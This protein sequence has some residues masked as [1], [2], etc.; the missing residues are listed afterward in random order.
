MKLQEILERISVS[1]PSDWELIFRPTFRHRFHEILNAD[2]DVAALDQDEH[3]VMFTL[4]S[5]IEISM[6]YGL[7]E[8]GAVPL[9]PDN[10]FANE[11]A[12]TVYLDIFYQGRMVHREVV[13]NID[14][15]RC[16]LPLPTSWEKPVLVP[17]AQSNLVKLIHS[18]AGPP[19]DFDAYFEKAGMR[20]ADVPWP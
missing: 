18:L 17:L 16:L 19:T 13:L 11:N 9:S 14:R 15:N 5:D 4:R 7:V 2:G 12:R 6:A 10:P 20:N 8:K 1:A 3:S